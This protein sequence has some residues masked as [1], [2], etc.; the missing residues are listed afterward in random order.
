MAIANT[1]QDVSN[2]LESQGVWS[3]GYALHCVSPT[4]RISSNAISSFSSNAY[5]QVGKNS[6]FLFSTASILSLRKFAFFLLSIHRRHG[7]YEIKCIHETQIKSGNAYF[8]HL[9]VN[10][11]SHIARCTSR[12]TA[13]L[14][15]LPSSSELVSLLDIQIR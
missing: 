2:S 1:V 5:F 12:K 10:E 7:T 8:F 14:H 3:A 15:T 11:T 6:A 13:P 9:E 4:S